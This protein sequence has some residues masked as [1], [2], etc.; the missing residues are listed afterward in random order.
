MV[1][2]FRA[3]IPV[4]DFTDGSANIEVQPAA[5]LSTIRGLMS[6]R[7]IMFTSLP[8]V[9][10]HSTLTYGLCRLLRPHLDSIEVWCKTMPE[11]GH[12][13]AVARQIE[14]LGC[15]VIRISDDAGRVNWRGVLSAVASTWRGPKPVFFTLAMRHL[16]LALSALVRSEN[17]IYY[18]ITH[19][20]NAGT[21]KRLKFYASFFRRIVF[22]CPATYDAF[23][24]AA[25]DPQYTW[26]PQSSE[27]PVRNLER[28]AAE[29]DAVLE[30][31]TPIRFGL[32]G[33]LTEDKGS[34]AM[35]EFFRACAVPCE[36][37]VAGTGPFA[38]TFREMAAAQLPAARV[39]FYGAYDP[40]EREAFLRTF[41]AGIDCLLVPSQ[42]EWETLSMATL[43]SL[44]HGVPAV[45]C[46]TGGLTSFAHPDL[47][48][49]AEEVV[50]LVAPA[51]YAETLV[52][53]ANRPRRAQA[54]TVAECRAYY[55][56]HFSDAVV[57]Q[58]WLSVVAP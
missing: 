25:A 13:E 3:R 9:G 58:R 16:S 55:D 19:D 53:L 18:H 40:S 8:R 43:E 29:R 51:D 26:V 15:R 42:D 48:P 44:Q 7:L 24:G 46:R 37:H 12:S 10:G 38:E 4:C 45:L 28:L 20:L 11:H 14:A 2:R 57:L 47:G 34:A 52:R 30:P 35:V 27:I 33:R 1:F 32:I 36:L 49:A 6:R 21:V 5:G 50:R 41:F 23:P 22:I 54:E 39:R 56:K 31:G 17:S